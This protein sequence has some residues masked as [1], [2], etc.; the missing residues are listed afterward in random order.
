MGS[1]KDP[2][3]RG[4]SLVASVIATRQAVAK[5]PLSD[6]EIDARRHPGVGRA[7]DDLKTQTHPTS[8]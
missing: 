5:T 2:R 4:V 1:L 6:V 7:I 8:K 3:Y